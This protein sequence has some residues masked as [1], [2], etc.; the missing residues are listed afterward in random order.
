MSDTMKSRYEIELSIEGTDKLNSQVDNIDRA[1][2]A[3][4][5]N[6]KSLKFDEALQGVK[7]L[8]NSMRELSESEQD[9]TA[10]WEE[11]DRVSNKTYADLE[12]EA[13]RLNHSISE[14]GRLQRERIKELEQE[15]AALGSTKEEKARAREI[16]KEIASI[17]KQVVDVSDDELSTMIKQNVQARGRLKLLQQ[18]SKAQKAQGKQQKTLLQ[19]IKEAAERKNCSSKRVYQ[20]IVHNR[21]KI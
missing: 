18:E 10:Q 15:K 20:V 5:K 1:L 16:D 8:E 7:A 21:W 6:A 4:S 19:L 12:R 9:C 2:E 3:I 17:R 14:Q 11:F 13:V